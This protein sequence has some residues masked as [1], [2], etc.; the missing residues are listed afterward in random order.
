MYSRPNL[1]SSKNHDE[2]TNIHVITTK[3]QQKT[4]LILYFTPDGLSSDTTTHVE[5]TEQDINQ[6]TS[7]E[8]LT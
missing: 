2:T 7:S 1:C 8:F 6:V 4:V 3:F 5:K